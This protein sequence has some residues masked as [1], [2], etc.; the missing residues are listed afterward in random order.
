MSLCQ[1][2]LLQ[3][4]HYSRPHR[5]LVNLPFDSCCY[6]T[7]TNHSHSSYPTPPCLHSL[8]VLYALLWMADSS[9]LPLL[10]AASLLHLIHT[11]EF[12]FVSTELTSISHT[13]A[14]YSHY[15]EFFL[16][17]YSIHFFNVQ[18]LLI[19][20]ALVCCICFVLFTFCM[21]GII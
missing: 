21:M 5:H 6:H 16:N 8:L 9:S 14:L 7:V 17:T 20:H 10:F 19:L 15:I 18:N 11:Q 13:P 1:C 2:Q 3:I 4:I 12:C